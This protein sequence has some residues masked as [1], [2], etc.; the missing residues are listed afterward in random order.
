M[1][2]PIF[3]SLEYEHNGQRMHDVYAM[4][5]AGF[6]EP[7]VVGFYIVA[8][9]ML[10]AHLSHGVSSMFQSLGLR[11]E[12]WRGWLNGFAVFYGWA[13]FLG[14][15]SVPV[16]VQ[17]SLHAGPQLVQGSLVLDQINDA[18]KAWNPAAPTPVMVNYNAASADASPVQTAKNP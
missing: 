10:C 15:A 4:V 1:V 5:I 6:S 17:L 8:V 7:V 14:F 2:H 13:I 11:N 16:A 9:G 12:K 3:E 18:Q